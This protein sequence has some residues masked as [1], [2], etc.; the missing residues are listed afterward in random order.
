M[1]SRI[2]WIGIISLVTIIIGLGVLVVWLRIRSSTDLASTPDIVTSSTKSVSPEPIAGDNRGLKPAKD[3]DGDG[4]P[5][6]QEARLGTSVFLRDTDGDGVTDYD[7]VSVLKTDPLVD[8]SVRTIP[9]VVSPERSVSQSQASSS[10]IVIDSDGDGLTDEQE[11]MLYKTDP[12]K[13]DTD[14]DGYPDGEEVTKGY[15]PRGQGKCSKPDC[16]P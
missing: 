16:A 14:G 2:K 9:P 12:N 5:D 13:K 4:L 8:N 3:T 15:N 1:N 11:L 6:E 7:E 10:P